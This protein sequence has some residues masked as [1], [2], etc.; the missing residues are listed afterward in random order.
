MQIICA[1]FTVSVKPKASLNTI[2]SR[3]SGAP[4]LTVVLVFLLVMGVVLTVSG[5]R[6]IIRINGYVPDFNFDSMAD[7]K[8]G[9]FVQGYVENIFDCYASETTT[10][11]FRLRRRCRKCRRL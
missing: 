3:T 11:T 6:D 5:V 10:E 2:R 8:K 7:I 9:G 1:V 4:V